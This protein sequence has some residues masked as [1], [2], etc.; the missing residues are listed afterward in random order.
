M[1]DACNKIQHVVVMMTDV[2]AVRWELWELALDV[3]T[4]CNHSAEY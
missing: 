3:W 2:S 1:R 4:L